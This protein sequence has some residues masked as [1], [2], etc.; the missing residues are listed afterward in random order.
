MF[1]VDLLGDIVLNAWS[2][3][4]SLQNVCRTRLLWSRMVVRNQVYLTVSLSKKLRQKWWIWQHGPQQ[5]LSWHWKEEEI[6]SEE[7]KWRLLGYTF[8]IRIHIH[9]NNKLQ[10]LSCNYFPHWITVSL[11]NSSRREAVNQTRQPVPQE[12]LPRHW[13]QEEKGRKSERKSKALVREAVKNYL[14]DFF[15]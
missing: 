6:K 3:S 12:L 10:C 11:S 14:A 13:K 2:I 1:G 4:P 5:L 7:S 9:T 8:I 15:R